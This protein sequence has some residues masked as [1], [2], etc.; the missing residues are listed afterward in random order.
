MSDT[1]HLSLRVS[2]ELAGRARAVAEQL[3]LPVGEV[4]RAALRGHLAAASLPSL[5]P[6]LVELCSAAYTAGWVE[7]RAGLP[8]GEG[9]PCQG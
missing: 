7:G 5:P 9:D 4:V 6:P 2:S 3:G 1:E 8:C